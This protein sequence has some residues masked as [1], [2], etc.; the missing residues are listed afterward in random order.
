MKKIITIL[1]IIIFIILSYKPSYYQDVRFTSYH[2]NDKTG[3]T[4]CTASG[5]CIKSFDINDEGIYTYDDKLV[6]ATPVNR[7]TKRV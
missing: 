1:L 6:I 4:K 7:C 5:Y 3:S 2:P